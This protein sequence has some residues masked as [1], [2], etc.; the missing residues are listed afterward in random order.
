V[1]TFVLHAQEAKEVDQEV[2]VLLVNKVELDN[3]EI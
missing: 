2:Q 3:L 1:L